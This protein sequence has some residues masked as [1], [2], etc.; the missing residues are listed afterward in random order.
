MN[1][2]D[3]IAGKRYFAGFAIATLLACLSAISISPGRPKIYAP[4]PLLPVF[5]LMNTEPLLDDACYLAAILFIPGLFSLWCLPI[6]RGD[7]RLPLRSIVLFVGVALL[8]VLWLTGGYSYGIQ[9][10]GAEYTLGII[11]VNG[12]WLAAVTSLLIFARR[13]LSWVHGLAFHTALFAWL[14]SSA[15][16]WLGEL[17]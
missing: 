11:V 2:G 9:Y 1:R 3:P 17:P 8:S 5:V 16:P 10:E 12:I 7:G 6:I 15:F 14:A 4:L 13:R